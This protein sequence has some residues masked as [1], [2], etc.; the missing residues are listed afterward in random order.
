MNET[1]FITLRKI[2]LC[3]CYQKYILINSSYHIPSKVVYY[4][5]SHYYE[6]KP[7]SLFPKSLNEELLA[8]ALS[9]FGQ[10]VQE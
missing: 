10:K 9:A 5:Y 7:A 8:L 1:L 4:D 3:V 6:E 2:L